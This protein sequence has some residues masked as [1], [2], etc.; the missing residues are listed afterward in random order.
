MEGSVSVLEAWVVA[1]PPEGVGADAHIDADSQE[2]DRPVKVLPR[3][4][5]HW[6][7]EGTMGLILSA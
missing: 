1:V 6:H 7:R 4:A 5:V 2:D 3:I